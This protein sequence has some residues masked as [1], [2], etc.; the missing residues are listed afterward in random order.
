MKANRAIRA[1]RAVGLAVLL[2]CAS[3][4]TVFSDYNASTEEA[5]LAF[6]A[7]D[8]DQATKLYEEEVEAVNDSLLYRLEAGMAAHVGGSYRKSF[9]LLDLAYK[10]VVEYQDEALLN[11]GN[12]AQS[13]GSV[14]VN[15]KTL[16][17]TGDLFEQV[18]LQAY[19]AKN[20]Y[21]SGK[22]EGVITEALRCYDILKKGRKIYDEELRATQAESR[23][24]GSVAGIDIE[25]KMREA[26]TYEKVLADPEDVY[27][28]RYV[29]YLVAWLRDAVATRQADY[30]SALIDMKYVADRF[31]DVPFVRRDLA[32]LTRLAGSAEEAK[33]LREKWGLPD[34][35]ADAGSVALF[36]EAGMAPRKRQFKLIFP[37]A[38]G[39]AAF[40]MPIY[41]PTPNPVRGALLEIGTH[42]AQS[43]VLTDVEQVCYQFHR[44]RLP[45][46]IARQVIRLA[47]KIGVQEGGRAAL[48]NNESGLAALAFT[49]GASVWNVV[50]EQAD[51]RGWRTLPSTLGA[52]RLYLPAG[53][54]VARLTL[55]GKGGSKLGTHQLGTIRVEAGRH[56]MI[57]ARSLGRRL[58]VDIPNE[59]YDD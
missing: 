36:F 46:M 48:A 27:D 16:P 2:V 13:V 11:V 18:L 34:L 55:L 8:F 41:E 26:Y 35:P 59:P 19:Q 39:A 30:N 57:N 12:V 6:E 49:I 4:C 20:V 45:L 1:T 28:M 23:G 31:G 10:R 25:G 32:R 24:Q 9:Q 43:L 22:R 50:S 29:R 14:V 51:L 47:I 58:F 40:A 38:T 42:S 54:H 17:Y 44:D 3:G 21:L 33:K 56:R 15:D 5:R 52:A 37:T 7:G 53:D